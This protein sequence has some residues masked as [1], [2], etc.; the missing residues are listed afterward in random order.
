MSER[1]RRRRADGE[2]PSELEVIAETVRDLAA[3]TS[4]RELL[5]RLLDRILGQFSAQIAAVLVRE[6]DGP[7]QVAASRGIPDS[8]R[9]ELCVLGIEEAVEEVVRNARPLR[10]DS[11]EREPRFASTGAARIHRGALLCVPMLVQGEVRGVLAVSGTDLAP[12]SDLRILEALAAYAGIALRAQRDA[13]CGLA[14]HGHFWTTLGVELKRAERYGRE[15]GVV[16]IDI[17]RFKDFN[18]RYGHAAGD[19]LLAAV[20]R[21]IAEGCRSSDL[22]ARYGGDEFAVILPETSLAGAASFGEK[23]RE[24]VACHPFGPGGEPRITISV[25]AAEFPQQA[26]S[27]RELVDAADAELYRA[28][29]SGRNRVSP[30]PS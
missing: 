23:I 7:L 9:P 13:L 16:M 11:I 17:D 26:R 18:D 27:P 1:E 20:A 2:R 12:E 24:S 6:N 22:A 25:G 29:S 14:N 28:K 3:A 8:A 15:L 10:V 21:L 4:E 5:Q 19:E 30:E